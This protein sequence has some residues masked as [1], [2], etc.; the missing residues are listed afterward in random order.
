MKKVINEDPLVGAPGR[1]VITE[2][3]LSASLLVGGS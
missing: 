2:K 1:Q 3:K